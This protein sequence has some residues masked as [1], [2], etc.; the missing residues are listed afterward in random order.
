MSIKNKA[1]QTAF[2]IAKGPDPLGKIYQNSSPAAAA[3][4]NVERTQ[5]CAFMQKKLNCFFLHEVLPARLEEVK[6]L[7]D[8]G[9]NVQAT[10]ENGNTGLI[11]ML[12]P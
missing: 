12:I 9:A 11:V 4:R 1:G 7:I 8:G 2:D 3:A 10:F 5:F 6:K